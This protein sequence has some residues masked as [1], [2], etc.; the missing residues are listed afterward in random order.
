MV[1]YFITILNTFQKN[2]KHCI[3]TVISVRLFREI[4]F[5]RIFPR[6]QTTQKAK[7]VMKKMVKCM[8][9]PEHKFK[10]KILL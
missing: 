4:F 3:I 2:L 10:M 7:N 9:K 8:I 6:F 5:I 1:L